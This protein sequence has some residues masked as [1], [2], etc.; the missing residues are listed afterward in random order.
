MPRRSVK[1]KKWLRSN[2]YGDQA[3][4]SKALRDVAATIAR[5]KAISD[6]GL[7]VAQRGRTLNEG[8]F[9]CLD[10]NQLLNVDS[11]SS[12]ALLNGMIHGDD[13]NNRIGREV[14]LKSLEFRYTCYSTVGT[15]S[16]QYHRIMLVYDRQANGSPILYTDVLEG[17]SVNHPRKLENRRRFKILYDRTH[18]INS[19]PESGSRVYRKFYRHLNHPVVFNNLN[20]GTIA[21]IQSGALYLVVLGTN[22]AGNTAGYCNFCF[23]LRYQDK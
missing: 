5:R 16:D 9:K 19:S 8:E 12:T 2:P 21:D 14:T 10:T 23:R 1:S 15:G 20:S 6:I 4:T 7:N 18:A 22:V 11:S 3:L 17:T 13:I